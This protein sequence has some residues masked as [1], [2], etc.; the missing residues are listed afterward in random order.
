VLTYLA[1]SWLLWGCG[2]DDGHAADPGTGAGGSAVGVDGPEPSTPAVGAGATDSSSRGEGASGGLSLAQPGEGAGA[3]ESEPLPTT[4]DPSLV[5]FQLEVPTLAFDEGSIVLVWHKPDNYADVI[6]YHVY[7]DGQ[8][9]GS[10]A[11]NNTEVS[12]A[13]AYI[14]DFYANDGAGFHAQ[15]S[16]HNFTVT[17]LE[18]GT[19]YTFTARSV[20]KDGTESADSNVVVQRTLDR[21]I[22]LDISAAPYR[23]LGDGTTLNTLAIQAAIDACPP[24]GKVLVPAGTFKTGALFLKSNM[25]FEVA[26][27]ATLLGSEHAEDYPLER[28]YT[29][30]EYLT[31]RRPPSLLNAIDQNDRSVGAF[32][33]IRIVGKGTIDGNGWRRATDDSAID[34]LGR[35]LP[36]YIAGNGTS[37]PTD[38]VLAGDQVTQAV[39]GGL[40]LAAA[41]SNRR[42]SLITLRGVRNA[43]YAGISAQNP[44]FHGIMNLESENVVVNGVVHQTY[45]INN[46]D[47]VEFGNS[48]GILVFNSVFD[49]GDDCINFAAGMGA[50]ASAQPPMRDAW[51]FNN[52]FREGHGAVVAGSHT[53][54][55]IEQVLAEDNVM[56]HTDIGLRM[57]SNVQTGGG[58]RDFVFRD[59]AIKD[60]RSE[61]FIF[62]LAYGSNDNVYASAPLPAQFRDVLVSNVSVDGAIASIRVDGF[63]PATAARNPENYGAVYHENIRFQNVA[64]NAVPPAAIDHLKDSS[65]ENVVFTNIVPGT[66]PW[67]I[68][69]SPGLVFLG[70]TPQP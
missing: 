3:G 29:L 69:N 37:V 44:A 22:V 19:E 40:A 59:S 68:T 34:E 18:P 41:Y 25:T 67:V 28:G 23:A 61:A 55:W 11:P 17:R 16:V 58:G 27:G 12:P 21:P 43:Y 20:L 7:M 45:D 51:I 49:T 26:E 10:A 66:S 54:A 63:D 38:G 64:L 47:G 52:Y 57:K 56:F 32:E 13:K 65:F 42:S 50:E 31:E 60:A 2:M 36:R 5:P 6:D 8:L 9:L 35:A 1:G 46:G 15:A 48:S 4:G 62:T 30:Y 53:G 14:D 24:G 33:N 39:A 70:T